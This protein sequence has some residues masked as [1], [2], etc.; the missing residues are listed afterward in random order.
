VRRNLL[1]FLT[2]LLNAAT[3]LSLLLGV[4]TAVA[5]VRSYGAGESIRYRHWSAGDGRGMIRTHGLKWSAGG[6]AI[7]RRLNAP[8]EYPRA[9]SEFPAG[10]S[11]R[12]HPGEAYYPLVAVPAEYVAPER[13]DAP[14]GFDRTWHGFQVAGWVT[15][16]TS[17][18]PRQESVWVTVPCW[19]L[20]AVFAILPAAPVITGIGHRVRR[21]QGKDVCPNC[22]YDLRAT[23]DRCPECGKA[24]NAGSA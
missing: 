6:V 23:P 16:E 14:R 15:P 12:R 10:W 4:A 13:D 11:F 22:G 17:G 3:V 5:W 8:M 19:A 20:V 21:T 24:P 9:G 7:V 2:I 1:V 18:E